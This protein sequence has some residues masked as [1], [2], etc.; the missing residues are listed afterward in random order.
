MVE[1]RV[2][3]GV[4]V[5]KLK[6]KGPLGIPKSRWEDN[7]K[8]DFQEVGGGGMDW[9]DLAQNMD[10]WRVFVNVVMNFRVP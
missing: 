6:G 4:V 5:G 1:I 2:V 9:I 8:M 3:Y 10:R 7:I